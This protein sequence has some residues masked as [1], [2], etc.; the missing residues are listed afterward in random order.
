M[1]EN[2][3]IITK[4]NKSQLITIAG[5]LAWMVALL[6]L[7]AAFILSPTLF[8]QPFTGMR[9]GPDL[10]L[11]V[12]ADPEGRLTI[13]DVAALPNSAFAEQRAS[14]NQGYTHTVYW[15]RL[16]PPPLEPRSAAAPADPLWL[17]VLPSY[18]DRVTLYQP[19][20][21][22]WQAQSSGDTVAMEQRVHVRQLV[23]PLQAGKP[24]VLRIQSQSS[25]QVY[26]TVWRS[27]ELMARLSSSE[28]SSGVHLG[29]GLVL[30]LLIAGAALALRMR[31]MTAL[32]LMSMVF[33][34]QTAITRGYPQVWLPAP[35]ARWN[36]V[37]A[38]IGTFILPAT[39]AWQTRELLTR[40]T[41]WR[42]LDRLLLALTALPLL[43]LASIPL[44]RFTQWAALGPSM[45]WLVSLL[46][47]AVTWTELRRKGP[48]LV[49][50]LTATPYS[51]HALLGFHVAA[52]YAGLVTLP[53]EAGLFW[54]L[55]ALLLNIMVAVAVGASLVQRF[56][57]SRQR[58]AQLVRSLEKSE[59]SLE[60]RVRQRTDE[61]LHAQNALQAALHSER[62][63]RL[64]QRQFFNMV[65]HEFRTPLA[66]VD[67]AATEQQSFPSA[68]LAAQQERA[69][70]IR[71]ACRRLTALVDNCLVSDRLDTTAFK[72]QRDWTPVHELVA[73]AAQLVHWSRRH[74]LAL[75]IDPR[76]DEWDCDPTLVRIA[77]S[78]LVD[79]AVK[80][81]REGEIA[82]AARL[83]PQGCLQLSVSD[84]GPGLPPEAAER[85]FERYERGERTD[86]TRGFG[87]GLWVA[88]RIARLH[89]GDVHAAASV[90]GG[91]RFTLTLPV[92]AG[93]GHI[94]NGF[95]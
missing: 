79:N 55:E 91:T 87:L 33:L 82:V 43:A 42:R 40:G 46:G 52:A 21:S 2:T 62:E 10:P 85:I 90:Q 64:E 17:E 60:E 39:F 11:H 54:Q 94:Y 72:L 34:L 89:G 4:T 76:L 20:D 12:L 16:A 93:N 69:A 47:V 3:Q 19:G 38:S 14:F 88:R 13:D 1:H 63:M 30:A 92:P 29:I 22:G 65:N 86:Q 73:D 77:L 80:Y 70:Q 59:H 24:L 15:L 37:A 61:L 95:I 48:S 78:N 83:D 44:G 26:G 31:S 75:D 41:A 58:Q 5:F 25:M 18:L 84:A 56:Q 68:D 66:V 53:A 57:D 74:Q 81:A 51:L 45:P 7:I 35:L 8:S 32:A 49:G 9:L 6:G 23:F 67:S 27:S 71:R 50:F 36:D 28:W